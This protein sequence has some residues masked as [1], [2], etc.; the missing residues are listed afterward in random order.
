MVKPLG[1]GTLVEIGTAPQTHL[2]TLN[3]SLTLMLP[4]GISDHGKMWLPAMSWSFTISNSHKRLL[5]IT[6]LKAV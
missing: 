1:L 2:H 5:S 3:D 4:K 6:E